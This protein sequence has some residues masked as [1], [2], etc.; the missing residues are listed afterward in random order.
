MKRRTEIQLALLV[1]GLIVWASGQ[2]FEEPRLQYAG[3]ACFAVATLLRFLK[4]RDPES[5][6]STSSEPPQQ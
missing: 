5:A 1:A 6:D 3:I 2:R 4:K